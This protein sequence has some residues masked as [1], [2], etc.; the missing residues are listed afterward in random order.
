MHATRGKRKHSQ[1][2]V[3]TDVAALTLAT[4]ASIASCNVCISEIMVSADASCGGPGAGVEAGAGGF[5]AGDDLTGV[6]K[7]VAAGSPLSS[8]SLAHLKP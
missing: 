6:F 7:A 3:R 5:G 2:K 1:L 4:P 8:M